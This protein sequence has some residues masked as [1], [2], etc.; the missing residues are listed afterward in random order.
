MEANY[1]ETFET[2][3][4]VAQLYEDKFMQLDLYDATYDY[5]CKA[6]QQ[7]NA[8]VLDVGCGPGNISRYILSKRPDFNVLGIDISPNMVALAQKNNPIARFELLD[9]RRVGTLQMK[10][11]G[12]VCGFCLPYLSPA[13]GAVFIKD[14]G[15]LLK[16]GGVAYLSFVAGAP[17]NSGFQTGSSGDRIY[18]HYYDTV[19]LCQQLKACG[20][21]ILEVFTLTYQRSAVLSETHN[22][23][24]AR[25]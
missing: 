7:Q 11:D 1:K 17:V 19:E 8:A 24:I 10:F 9:S 21:Q 23:I 12:I 20:L 4:K 15:I 25:K 3:N 14:M 5:F 18:F 22:V 13:D 2:W 16:D 6:V